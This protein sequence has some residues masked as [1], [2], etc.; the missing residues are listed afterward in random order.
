PARRVTQDYT[1]H[2]L[3]LSFSVSAPAAA[4]MAA[5]NMTFKND[6]T[7]S[8]AYSC[9]DVPDSCRTCF[10]PDL[11]IG[12]FL[13]QFRKQTGSGNAAPPPPS[14]SQSEATH[15]APSAAADPAAQQQQQQTPAYDASAYYAYN[16]YA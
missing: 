2:A 10:S 15:S 3:A 7:A 6:G 11:S 12:S 13:E 14:A 9:V 5:P 8:L 1:S 16:A 4:A